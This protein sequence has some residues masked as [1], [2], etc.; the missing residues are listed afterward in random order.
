MKCGV[1]AGDLRNL[2]RNVQDCANGGEI[3]RLMKRRQRRKPRKVVQDVLCHPHRAIVAQTAMDNTVTE[4]SNRCSPQQSG[5]H[6]EDLARC[7]VMVK[8]FGREGAFLD[9]PALGVGDPQARRDANRVMMAIEDWHRDKGTY[10]RALSELIPRYLPAIPGEPV[11][12]YRASDGSLGFR[13]VPTWPQLR[14]VW[15]ASVG[16][17]T[18]WVCAEHLLLS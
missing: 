3:V 14:P 1:E 12:H 9:D 6:G 2:G 18:N 7:R 16:A 5:P 8:A 11:L 4:A 17:T 13:Y 10:P 15:C